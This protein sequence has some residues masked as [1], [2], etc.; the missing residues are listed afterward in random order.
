V[1]DHAPSSE[2]MHDV[3]L[4]S[5]RT[6]VAGIPGAKPP[7]VP[8]SPAGTSPPG[9]P[10]P[11]AGAA[12]SMTEAGMQLSEKDAELVLLPLKLACESKQPKL[13]E[14]ALDCLHVSSKGWLGELAL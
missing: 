4:T 1:L 2:E 10:G 5:P 13:V 11:A 6:P 14:T 7:S 9:S 3:A 8:S 12:A